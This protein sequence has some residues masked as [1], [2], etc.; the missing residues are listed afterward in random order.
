MLLSVSHISKSFGDNVIISDAVFNIDEKEKAAIV[1][2][3]GAGKTT[4][5]NIIAGSSKPDLG[6]VFLSSDKTVGYLKQN[7][8]IDSDSTL[9]DEVFFANRGLIELETKMRSLER[10]IDILGENVPPYMINEYSSASSLFEQQNGYAYRSEVTGVLKGLGFSEDDFGKKI[11]TLS[12]GMKTRVSLAKLLLTK[13]DL[14]ILDEPTNHLDVSS[15]KWLENYLYSYPGA[16]LTVAHDRYFLD[17]FVTKII[18]IENTRVSVFSG[19]YSD[20]AVKK[21]MLYQAQL[22]AWEKD[23]AYIKHQEKVIEK[24]R[25]YNREKSIK[26]AESR[27]K[28]LQKHEAVEK[29]MGPDDKIKLTFN[30]GG[31]RSGDRVLSVKGLSKSYGEKVLF[32]DIDMEV[33]RGEKIAIIGD[34]GT[35]KTTFMKILN[36]LAEA[37]SGEITYGSNVLSGYYDQ[38]QQL[39]DDSKQVFDE[40]SDAYPS[41]DN[42]AIRNALALFLFKGD[43]VFKPV[44]ALS[45]GERARLALCKLI[46]SPCN[47][48]MLDEP[49]N[50]M[51]MVS[52]EMLESALSKYDGTLIFVSHDRYFINKLAGRVI[53]IENR[54][55]CDYAGNYEYYLQKKEEG[56]YG[57]ATAVSSAKSDAASDSKQ[58]RLRKKAA[59]SDARKLENEKNRLQEELS[60]LDERLAEIDE[61]LT[62]EEIY[63]NMDECGRLVDEQLQ[64]KERVDELFERW[65]QLEQ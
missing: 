41:M 1:G 33:G 39:L 19:N 50:H 40:I 49:T 18:E 62:R 24:L 54:S 28:A 45:G 36:S 22:K 11:D 16:V 53:E 3:N 57:G 4:L 30:T 44:S 60:R 2:I 38:E 9:Y 63:T 26:R 51:D 34:N 8:N 27:V 46:L 17:R 47:L 64:L 7:H 25:S 56:L 12:G 20:Y 15:V 6:S 43:D 37:D 13:P 5:L 42:T 48:L 29:P 31:V 59:E 21:T 14:I 10:Q 58:E 52:K 32:K 55:F 65:E 61:L 35:G 23:R